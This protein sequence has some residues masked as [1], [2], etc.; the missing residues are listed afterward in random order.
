[1]LNLPTFVKNRRL[2]NAVLPPA[3]PAWAGSL[4]G[5][6]VTATLLELHGFGTAATIMLIIAALVAGTITVGWLAY[7]SPG[8]TPGVMPAWAMVSMGFVSLGSATTRVLGGSAGDTVWWFHFGCCV[9]GGALG[10]TTCLIYLRLI[11]TRRA[12]QPSFSWGIP[13]VT[14][15]VTSTAGMQV[16]GWLASINAPTGYTTFILWLSIGAFILSLSIA[17]AVFARVYYFYFGRHVQRTTQNRLEPM[18]APTTWIPLGVAGQSTA[19]SQLLGEAS[20]WITPVIFYGFFML[21]V[22]IPI[23]L[24]AL[25]V[26][27]QAALR[28]ISYSPTWW[29]STFPVGTL[30][31][32][33]YSLALTTGFHWLDSL[34]LFLLVIL[35]IHVGVA[36]V[37]GT[38]AVVKKVGRALLAVAG[39][40]R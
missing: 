14:P 10:L 9:I 35:L 32:G 11:L 29:A 22:A 39:G 28:G 8:F 37:G 23:G 33:T 36:T 40:S 3:G 15:M 38:I 26:H 16:H 18:A 19:S 24:I 27:Y 20:G 1:M 7:R 4:M 31:L 17:P 13:M 12:G 5:T 6:S 21:V 2:Y 30:S 25:V 34:S